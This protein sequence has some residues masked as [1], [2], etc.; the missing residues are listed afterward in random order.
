MYNNLTSER[1]KLDEP[2]VVY[3][4]TCLACDPSH[5]SYPYYIGMTFSTLKIRLTQN[6]KRSNQ[7]PPYF[8]T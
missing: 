4:I 1:N 8:L 6:K 5:L 7:I 2:H 3:K